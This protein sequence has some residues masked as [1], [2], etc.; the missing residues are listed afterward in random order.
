[1][2]G[3]DLALSVPRSQARRLAALVALAALPL[4]VL[5]VFF[6]VPVAGMLRRGVVVDGHVDLGAVWDV[7]ARPRTRRVVWFTAWSAAAGTAA[8]R[9]RGV[10]AAHPLYRLRLPGS[11][12]LRAALAVP[13][14]LPPVVRGFAFRGVGPNKGGEPLGGESMANASLEYK[15]PLYAVA[16]PGTYKK[17]EVFHSKLFV[18]AGLLDPDAWRLDPSELRASLG[19][20]LGMSYPIPISL[21]F[22]FPIATGT[23]DQRETFSF[24][25]VNIT[26]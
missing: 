19:F 9:V 24:S 16:Q 1:M 21:N 2:D 15:I 23:D 6:V 3:R 22:G 11:A 13:F 12:L 17:V 7:L 25:I 10:A 5:C 26:F 18:D 20:S 4:A 14:V 8:S